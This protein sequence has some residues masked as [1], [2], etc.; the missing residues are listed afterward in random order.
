M[1]L[2]SDTTK[3]NHLGLLSVDVECTS[4]QT[5]YESSYLPGEVIASLHL[6]SPTGNDQE[7]GIAMAIIQVAA[8]LPMRSSSGIEYRHVESLV[9]ALRYCA[10]CY[11]HVPNNEG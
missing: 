3:G 5:R 6:K 11:R 4:C 10:L 2:R 9:G 8:E 1:R 7:D